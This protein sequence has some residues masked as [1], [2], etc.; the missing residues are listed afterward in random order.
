M[1][2]LWRHPP[3]ARQLDRI[4]GTG[5]LERRYRAVAPERRATGQRGRN[6]GHPP[7]SVL[8]RWRVHPPQACT[9]RRRRD[10]RPVIIVLRPHGPPCSIR[11]FSTDPAPKDLIEAAVRSA[12]T[13]PC[14]AHQQP[15]TS[16]TRS[17]ASVKSWVRADRAEMA[18]VVDRSLSAGTDDAWPFEAPFYATRGSA[19]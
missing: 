10:E 3:A 18:A 13:V 16:G 4:Q 1:L 17:L 11:T 15:W 2:P 7:L 5:R 6:R 14:G 12:G 19:D 9:S 8:R